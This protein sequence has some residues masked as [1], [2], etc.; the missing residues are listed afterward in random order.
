M[1]CCCSWTQVRMHS[2]FN[3]GTV[4]EEST[5]RLRLRS[6]SCTWFV[7]E[8]DAEDSVIRLAQLP[9]ARSIERSRSDIK[10]T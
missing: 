3:L 6:S 1:S 9:D 4:S 8:T 2:V 7:S 5:R 10:L